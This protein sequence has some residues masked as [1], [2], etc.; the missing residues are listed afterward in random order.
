MPAGQGV[1]EDALGAGRAGTSALRWG[2][3][4][5]WVGLEESTGV[6]SPRTALYGDVRV[7]ARPV[8]V[9]GLSGSRPESAGVQ[10]DAVDEDAGDRHGPLCKVSGT[11]PKTRKRQAYP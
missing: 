6:E 4:S 3:G 7:Q 8:P 9:A 2:R 1:R 11:N 5:K 10:K